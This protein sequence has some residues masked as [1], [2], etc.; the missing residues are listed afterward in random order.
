[1]LDELARL[2]RVRIL[3]L[4]AIRIMLLDSGVAERT[5]NLHAQPQARGRRATH[6]HV[7]LEKAAG[8]K[9]VLLLIFDLGEL[10]QGG[11]ESR[12]DLERRAKVSASAS[13]IAA[14]ARTS[15]RVE[16]CRF[17]RPVQQILGGLKRKLLAALVSASLTEVR[18]VV[19][20]VLGVLRIQRDRALIVR[21]GL[22][23]FSQALVEHARRGVS[24]RIARILLER[25]IELLLRQRQVA[26]A[27]LLDGKVEIDLRGT[28][29]VRTGRATRAAQI[30]RASCRERV[31][32]P[33]GGEWW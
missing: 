2:I 22:V 33:V 20:L 4:Q 3:G 19:V 15:A 1:G 11:C 21:V 29:Q 30:G 9:V 8:R 26:L 27:Q 25:P 17:T 12:T 31:W 28:R 13:E 7:A 32:T 14:A 5:L 16:K 6:F 10:Q 24:R 23:G 18:G